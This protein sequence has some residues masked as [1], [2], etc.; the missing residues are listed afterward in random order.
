MIF[1]GTKN[2]ASLAETI[3]D[4]VFLS[5]KKLGIRLISQSYFLVEK[6]WDRVSKHDAAHTLGEGP[7]VLIFDLLK[8]IECL[9]DPIC[10][11]TVHAERACVQQQEDA[12]SAIMH[13]YD[14]GACGWRVYDAEWV[15]GRT[16]LPHIYRIVVALCHY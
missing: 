12:V 13:E 2:N 3:N 14:D 16:N 1:N 7:L 6:R 9:Q 15:L 4:K 5:L 8:L 11:E 10:Q